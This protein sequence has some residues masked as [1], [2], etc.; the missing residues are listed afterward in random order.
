MT[1]RESAQA[2]ADQTFNSFIKVSKYTAYG[3]IAF[4]LFV[5]SCN[6]GVEDGPNATGSGYDGSVYNPSNLKVK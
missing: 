4:F 5:A 1:P 3:A 6:F 2:E